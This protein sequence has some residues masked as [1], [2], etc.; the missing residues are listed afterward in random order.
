MAG[1]VFG[2][3]LHPSEI[4]GKLAREAD[5][6]R[7]DHDT[8][9]ATANSYRLLVNPRDLTTDPAELER[10]LV[11]EMTSY[12]GQEGLRVEGPITVTIEASEEVAPGSVMCQVEVVPGTPPAWARLVGEGITYE[13]RFNRVLIGRASESDVML[14][15]DDI[16]RRHA[17]LWR[18]EGRTWIRDLASANGT[19]IDGYPVDE[20]GR[21]VTSGSVV[22]LSQHRFRFLE[23]QQ[24]A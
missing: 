13:L 10:H 22:G 2:G 6:A 14:P 4:A 24:S 17:L 15:H 9:P 8:G 12:V 5:F 11:D 19:F 3:R 18:Q 16:S 21:Q 7:F 20:E 1:K 23:G